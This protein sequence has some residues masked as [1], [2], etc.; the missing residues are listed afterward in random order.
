MSTISISYQKA[1]STEGSV[2]NEHRFCI[3]PWNCWF[4]VGRSEIE[5]A[6]IR[7]KVRWSNSR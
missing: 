2:S 5:P 3:D 7:L 6:A 4:M 1:V